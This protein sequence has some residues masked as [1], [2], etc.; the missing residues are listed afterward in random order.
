MDN[1]TRAQIEAALRVALGGIGVDA[2][3]A[4]GT[5]DRAAH[6]VTISG[7]ESEINKVI[8]AVNEGRLFVT[9]PLNYSANSTVNGTAALG[10]YRAWPGVPPS[11]PSFFLSPYFLLF[12]SFS[13]L[14][15]CV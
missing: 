15:F 9:L 4:L 14:S 3:T 5:V 6:S 12:P 11:L 7:K 8:Q 10:S 2:T 1:I 13:F